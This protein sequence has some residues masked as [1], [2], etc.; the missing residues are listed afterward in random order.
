MRIS[1]PPGVG[2]HGG[3]NGHNYGKASAGARSVT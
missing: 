3:K 1:S 2:P